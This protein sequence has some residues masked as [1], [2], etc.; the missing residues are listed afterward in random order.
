MERSIDLPTPAEQ[1]ELERQLYQ[2]I[3]AGQIPYLDVPTDIARF[4]ST[5]G[6]I[7]SLPAMS[8]QERIAHDLK[9]V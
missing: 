4:G 8:Q 2:M 7:Q 9:R 3:V 1:L 6:V 5:V